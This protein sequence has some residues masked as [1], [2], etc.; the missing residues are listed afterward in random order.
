VPQGDDDD[1]DGASQLKNA[2]AIW[3]RLNGYRDSPSH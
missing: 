3:A 1:F 2:T